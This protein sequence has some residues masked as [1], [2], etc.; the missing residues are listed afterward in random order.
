[1]SALCLHRQCTGGKLRVRHVDNV[2]PS[3]DIFISYRYFY[4]LLHPLWDSGLM[5]LRHRVSDA[6][7]TA[8][9]T[10]HIRWTQV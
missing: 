3:I 1:V 10:A 5:G 8:S 6:L 2:I 4:H 9:F 7:R